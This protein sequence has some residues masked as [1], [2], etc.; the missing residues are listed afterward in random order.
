M[1]TI[2]RFSWLRSS[3]FLFLLSLLLLSSRDARADVFS[4]YQPAPSFSLP[5]ASALFDVGSDGRVVSLD[6]A[7]VYRESAPGSRAFTMLGT[8]PA[9]DIPSF[10]AAFIR[11][12]PSGSQI[13]VGNNGGASFANF[14]VGVFSLP[15]LTG[16]WF[17]AGHFDAAWIDNRFLAVT[18]GAFGSPGVVT[19]LDTASPNPASPSNVTVIANV[20]GASGGIAFDAAGNLYTANGFQ[21]SGPS[22]TGEVHAFKKAAWTAAQAGGTALNFE[23]QGIPIVDLLSGSPLAFDLAGDLLVGGGNSFGSPPDG[24]YFAIVDAPAVQTAL[25][26]GGLVNGADSSK[27]RKL[28]PDSGAGSFYSVAANATRREIYAVNV[29]SATVFVYSA[30]A[31]A[32]PAVPPLGLLACASLLLLAGRRR[33]RARA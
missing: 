30:A 7:T 31:A 12:S 20:G 21:E 33:V 28:D 9:G 22:Q 10:G 2:R 24:N 5:S 3:S 14:Q 18:A 23:T 16:T 19:A 17:N 4:S 25:A 6:G 15:A 8:L 13:A 29:G 26:G 27:V 32:V 11:V 1:T